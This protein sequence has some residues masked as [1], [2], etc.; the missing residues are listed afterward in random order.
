MIPILKPYMPDLPRIDDLLHSGALASG[1]YTI[2]FENSL[3]DY[4]G[5]PNILVTNS[6]S[7]AISVVLTTMNIGVGD[8]IIA[9]PMACLAS[10]QP[11]LAHGV[12]V[13]WADIDPQ[14]GTLEPGSVERQIT[15][16]TRAIIHNHFCGYPGYIDEINQL[17][18]KYGIPVIDDGI[19]CFGSQYKERLIGNCGT[20]VTIFS[21]GPVRI[22]NTIDGGIIIFKDQTL[23][24]K[25]IL[26]R[27]CGIDRTRFRDDIGEISPNCDIN[28]IGYSATMSNINAYIGLKQMEKITDILCRQRKQADKWEKYLANENKY[29]SLNC[30]GN[31]PNYWVYGILTE[32]K[33]ETIMKFREMGY[34]ASGIHMKNNIYSVFG[35]QENELPGVDSF[36]DS[37]VALPCGWWLDE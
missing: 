14:R 12:K 32:C 4:F 20:D 23:Y 22:P 17:G 34:Y 36:F 11:Y 15:S 19:E 28:L 9:S 1:K 6:F 26:I 30:R 8:E 10:T 24:E 37:F 27:D 13:K 29:I 5:T 3:K 18:F 31:D 16:K 33:R 2:E 21:C 35:E 7:M 25:G